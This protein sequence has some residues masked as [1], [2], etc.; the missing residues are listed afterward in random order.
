MISVFLIIMSLSI[1]IIEKKRLIW[2]IIGKMKM[3]GW[4]LREIRWD[5]R[6]NGIK[7]NW[8]YFCNFYFNFSYFI[9]TSHIKWQS[10][11]TLED[12]SSWLKIN[13]PRFL[14][15]LI[16][17]DLRKSTEKTKYNQIQYHPFGIIIYIDDKKTALDYTQLIDICNTDD[18]SDVH[19]EILM[20]MSECKSRIININKT[21]QLLEVITDI[22]RFIT[23]DN[24][25]IEFYPEDY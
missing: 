4:K 12:S 14:K 7:F 19:Y 9:F 15:I 17:F 20:T 2:I 22:K 8:F 6:N 13:T 11:F 21:F 24:K 18:I 3:K 5:R 1:C 25:T 23:K 16:C 10:I